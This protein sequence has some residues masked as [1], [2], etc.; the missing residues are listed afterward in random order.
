M[1]KK[2]KVAILGCGH[3]GMALAADL[4]L[5]GN[6]VAIWTDK[7]HAEKFNKISRE[8]GKI[9]L[10]ENGINESLRVD[11]MSQDIS[12]IMEFGDIIYNCTPMP[13][14]VSLFKVLNQS[15]NKI[16]KVKILINFSGVFSGIDQYLSVE[17]KRVFKK[18][19]IFDTPSFPY[20]CRAG[21]ANDVT[22]LGRKSV[23]EIAPL[24]SADLP[25][26]EV[27][28]DNYIDLKLNAIEN[29]FKLGLMGTNSVFHP[30]TLLFNA[31]LVDSG[32]TFL[33][34][35]EGISKNT[36]RLHE[37]LDKERVILAKAMGYDLVS[38]VEGDNRY[39]GTN[40]SN[41]Y[42]FCIKSKVHEN[43]LSPGSLNHR[44]VIEDIAHGLVPLKSLAGLYDV[45]LANIESVINIFSTI[46]SVDYYKQGRNLQGLTKK[47]IDELS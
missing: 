6:K 47:Q 4:K 31:R 43:I 13:A 32:S 22:I 26:I 44:F 37:A 36:S 35:R 42:D 2:Y 10:K 27:I 46:M 41:S 9:I 40:F 7:K 5:K 45:K 12:E 24:I 29:L 38:C 33:F 1:K 28:Q 30:A 23:L 25:L 14:H 8:H 21:D 15:I 3:G 39:Y 18:I 19:K 17:D 34:Y 16:K 20:A 11:L